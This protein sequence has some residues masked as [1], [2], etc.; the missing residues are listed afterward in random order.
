M[1]RRRLERNRQR[2]T[3]DN[4]P[5]FLFSW[6]IP[7]Q[8]NKVVFIRMLV[9]GLWQRH[10]RSVDS[11]SILVGKLWDW[12]MVQT[13]RLFVLRG[14]VHSSTPRKVHTS[15]FLQKLNRLKVTET[16]RI[17][18]AVYV[19]AYVWFDF[20][21]RLVDTAIQSTNHW[22]SGGRKVG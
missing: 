3:I 20:D 11:L 9:W 1:I 5:F 7:F 12:L 22:P 10:Y 4:F 16:D 19:R 8:Q 18:V 2:E 21:R 6:S 15:N 13:L 14:W 17:L